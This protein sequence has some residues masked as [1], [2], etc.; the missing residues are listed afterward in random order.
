[1]RSFEYRRMCPQETFWQGCWA[2]ALSAHFARHTS[3]TSG[4]RTIVAVSGSRSPW[5]SRSMIARV[6]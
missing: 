2:M 4:L 5:F 3:E 6:V 1:M